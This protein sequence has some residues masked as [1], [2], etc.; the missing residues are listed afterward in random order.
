MLRE[1]VREKKVDKVEAKVGIVYRLKRPGW[2][3]SIFNVSSL[4]YDNYMDRLN[5]IEQIFS[6]HDTT[7]QYRNLHV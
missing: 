7:A 4:L 5:E 1:P 6:E 2:W 3:N